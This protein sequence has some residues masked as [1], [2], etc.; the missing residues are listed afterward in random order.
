M[1]HLVSSWYYSNASYISFKTRDIDLFVPRPLLC[2][3]HPIANYFVNT[4]MHD[5][6]SQSIYHAWLYSFAQPASVGC[7][8]AS[9]CMLRKTDLNLVVWKVRGCE[10]ETH[11]IIISMSSR[12]WRM[13]TTVLRSHSYSTVV[14][15][16]SLR[17]HLKSAPGNVRNNRELLVASRN[18]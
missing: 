14:S 12:E 4:A 9:R 15:N 5:L 6:F 16:W 7:T 10:R 13:E 18:F 8:L 11:I 1:S 17:L 2:S 3:Y